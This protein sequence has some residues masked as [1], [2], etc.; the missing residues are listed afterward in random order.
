MFLGS[1]NRIFFLSWIPL[2]ILFWKL[3][4]NIIRDFYGLNND[5]NRKEKK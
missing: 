3:V 5:D 4:D 2:G 1:T